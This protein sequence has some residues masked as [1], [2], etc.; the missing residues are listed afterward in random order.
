M[1]FAATAWAGVDVGKTH[2]WVGVVEA[3]GVTL[4]SR[5]VGND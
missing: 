1:S 3:C 2:H 5:R 4:L